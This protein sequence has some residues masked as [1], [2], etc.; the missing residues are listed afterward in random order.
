M[1][2]FSF[3]LRQV[4]GKRRIHFVLEDQLLRG[5]AVRVIQDKELIEEILAAF[6]RVLLLVGEQALLN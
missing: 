2:C 3:P 5:R 4:L 1:D 6:K